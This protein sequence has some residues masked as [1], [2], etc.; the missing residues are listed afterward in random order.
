MA[1]AVEC[2]EEAVAKIQAVN[3]TGRFSSTC[4]F[5]A[6]PSFYSRHNE[7]CGGKVL[8]LDQHLKGRNA[9]VILLSTNVSEDEIREYGMQVTREYLEGIDT[10]AKSIDKYINWTYINYADK[11]QDPI[12]SLLDPAFLQKTARKY[13]RTGVF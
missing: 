9:I 2:H 5:Q 1:K 6:L 8:G 4:L 12:G 7:E 13:D 10:Y 3:K 11:A